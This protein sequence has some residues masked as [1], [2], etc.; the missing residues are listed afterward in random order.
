MLSEAG[1]VSATETSDIPILD[2]GYCR[3]KSITWSDFVVSVDSDRAI[4]YQRWS[5][6]VGA[7][8]D[9]VGVFNSKIP[10]ELE[11]GKAGPP[12]N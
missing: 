9:L 8:T 12:S 1:D 5:S 7:T 3:D 10:M 11:N 2:S 6:E 4:E